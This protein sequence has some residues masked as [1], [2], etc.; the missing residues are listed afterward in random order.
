MSNILIKNVDYLT[1]TDAVVK[2]G[3]I[4]IEGSQIQAI[5]QIQPALLEGKTVEKIDG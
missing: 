3:D 2:H 4:L 5:G 1:M